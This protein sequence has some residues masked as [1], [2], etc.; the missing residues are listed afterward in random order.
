MIGLSIEPVQQLPYTWPEP[1]AGR[2]ARRHYGEAD[3][4]PR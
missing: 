4:L 2:I 3:H 1:I